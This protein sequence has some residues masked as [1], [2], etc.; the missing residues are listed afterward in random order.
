MVIVAVIKYN[1][2]YYFFLN[3]YWSCKKMSTFFQV[4]SELLLQQTV[5]LHKSTDAY[6]RMLH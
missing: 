3:A 4:L 5:K 6:M 2:L 1:I